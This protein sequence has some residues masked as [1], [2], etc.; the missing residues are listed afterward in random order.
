MVLKGND[1][2]SQ[3]IDEGQIEKNVTETEQRQSE[4]DD[5]C[6]TPKRRRYFCKDKRV[7]IA[8]D[9]KGKESCQFESVANQLRKIGIHQSH[10]ML[11]RS[12]VEH[13]WYNSDH[14]SDY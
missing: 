1:A 13:I 11:R 4:V 6:K 9:P 12:A 14:Y 7:V 10:E 5:P 2:D 8:M 3:E